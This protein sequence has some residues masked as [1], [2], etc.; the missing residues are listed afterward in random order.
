MSPPFEDTLRLLDT[1]YNEPSIGNDRP[2]LIS[3][4]ALL[5]LCGWIEVTFDELIYKVDKLTINDTDWVSENLIKKTNG[6]TYNLHLRPMIVKLIG[7]V[8]ARR[9]EQLMEEKYAGELDRMKSILGSLWDKRCSFAH[10]N[11]AV[12]IIAQ[13]KFDAPSWS[14][15]QHRVLK[16]LFEKYELSL[17]ETLS[18]L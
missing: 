15:N 10:A 2:K 9:V 13:T 18:D 5:E 16:K 11:M 7:E 3:K 14:S 8:L 4:L 12:N 6:F 1:W 17:N